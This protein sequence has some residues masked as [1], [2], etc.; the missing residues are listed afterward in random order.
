MNDDVIRPAS[1]ILGDIPWGRI[2][3]IAQW[4]TKSSRLKLD[5]EPGASESKTE[6]GH[7][8]IETVDSSV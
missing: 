1:R 3:Q 7:L 4:S 8:N 2:V 6:E 5:A